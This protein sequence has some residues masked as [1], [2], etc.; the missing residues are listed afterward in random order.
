MTKHYQN[1]T[2]TINSQTQDNQQ[3]PSRTNTM[4]ITSRRII[5]KLLKTKNKNFKALSRKMHS[6]QRDKH[7]SD[8][9]TDLFS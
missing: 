3:T 4:K 7:K 5:I 9:I 2:K 8:Y 1:L 6:I